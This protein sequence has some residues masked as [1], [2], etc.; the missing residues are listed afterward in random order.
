[1]SAPVGDDLHLGRT[2]R[3]NHL[4]D[5]FVNGGVVAVLSA[6]W[7]IT[8]SIFRLPLRTGLARLEAA[9]ALGAIA[10]SGKPTTAQTITPEPRSRLAS[11]GHKSRCSRTRCKAVLTGFRAQLFDFR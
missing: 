6:P 3:F 11:Q 9:L 5:V 4:L 1:M 2:R 10:P 7:F 8:M